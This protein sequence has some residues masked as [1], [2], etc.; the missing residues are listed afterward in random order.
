[1]NNPNL[2]NKDP[3]PATRVAGRNETPAAPVPE[4]FCLRLDWNL[5]LVVGS[6]VSLPTKGFSTMKFYKDPKSS[7]EFLRRCDEWFDMRV[8]NSITVPIRCKILGFP[9]KNG[10]QAAIQ[11][12]EVPV[13]LTYDIK[14][15]V[16]G[17][18]PYEINGVREAI[19]E[20]DRQVRGHVM[21]LE[22]SYN[23]S[24][25]RQIKGYFR[26]VTCEWIKTLPPGPD[27]ENALKRIKRE[28]DE[29]Y[30]EDMVA[31]DE[32]P[33]TIRDIEVT[34]RQNYPS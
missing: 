25:F 13:K 20:V 21:A 15:S 18:R 10:G 24:I 6:E 33:A 7:G 19:I 30:K 8:V 5:R 29:M 12:T 1:M 31:E 4:Q 32:L 34:A 2:P 28:L 26:C 3:G 14:V 23:L 11:G 27:A 9:A 22:Q 17:K 16:A